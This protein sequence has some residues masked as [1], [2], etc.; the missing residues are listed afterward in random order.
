M[1]ILAGWGGGAEAADTP[2]VV[3]LFFEIIHW[4]N[5]T[6]CVAMETVSLALMYP[7]GGSSFLAVETPEASCLCKLLTAGHA[8]KQRSSV[9]MTGRAFSRWPRKL[10]SGGSNDLAILH[11]KRNVEMRLR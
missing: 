7:V 10:E 6:S 9:W 3:F 5:K 1:L 8:L 4:K 2:D 11:L